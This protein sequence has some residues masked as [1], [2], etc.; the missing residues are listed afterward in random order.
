MIDLDIL[1]LGTA[2]M[3]LMAA[4]LLVLLVTLWGDSD[5]L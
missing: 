2:A 4:L 5:G 1:L 3:G